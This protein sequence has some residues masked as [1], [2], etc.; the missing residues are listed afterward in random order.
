MFAAF[1]QIDPALLRPRPEDFYGEPG[2]RFWFLLRDEEPV[3][4]FEQDQALAWSR[5]G[6]HP[7]RL[8]ALYRRHRRDV[9]LTATALLASAT[10]R[11]R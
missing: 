2:Y 6:Q 9:T 7:T 3:L 11:R 10:P 1:P 5:D 4:A 8:S